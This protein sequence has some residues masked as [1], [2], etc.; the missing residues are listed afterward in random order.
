MYFVEGKDPFCKPAFWLWIWHNEYLLPG[1]SRQPK[2]G[3]SNVSHA[4]AVA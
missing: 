1:F 2:E 4:I 3:A